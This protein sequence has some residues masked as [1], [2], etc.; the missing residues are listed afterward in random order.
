MPLVNRRVQRIWNL[1]PATSALRSAQAGVRSLFGGPKP[2]RLLLASDGSAYTSE[3]QFAP[4]ARH[5]ASLRERLGVVAEHRKLAD[6]LRMDRHALAC[7]DVVGFKLRFTTAPEE[8]ARVAQHFAS[9]LAGTSTKLV[10]FDGDDDINVQWHDVIESVDVYVKKHVFADQSAYLRHYV[11]KS[12][13]TDYVSHEYG[14]SFAEDIIPDS[15]SLD[16][17]LLAKLHV[18]WN[19]AVDDKIFDLSRRIASMPDLPRDIDLSCR[20]YVR[21]SV[22]THA[23]RNAALERM[24]AMADRFRILAPRDRVTQEKYYEEMLRSKICVSPFGFG[25]ICWR[26]FEAI[27]CGCLLVK[28]DM[29]HVR[30]QPD[31][32]LPD[33]TYVPVRPDYSDLEERCAAYLANEDDRARIVE[34][35]RQRLLASLKPAWFLDRFSELLTRLGFSAASV[36]A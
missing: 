15:G 4:I 31:I 17:A 24:E 22:W 30:S 34:N 27:L 26:D 6:T 2:I 16:R 18:G 35:A 8:A 23:L 20:G 5:A 14:V 1:H 11:G 28:P 10:Y 9:A 33:I 36:P 19:I 3:Q 21:P 25:E 32:F 13:L 12:N 7:F 29:T